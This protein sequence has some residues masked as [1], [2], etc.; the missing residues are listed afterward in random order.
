M[1]QLSIV[2]EEVDGNALY[3]NWMALADLGVPENMPF[4]ARF[5]SDI[6][7]VI[8]HKNHQASHRSSAF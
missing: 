1:K 7:L 4:C 8:S 2:G 3:F 5:I 6:P